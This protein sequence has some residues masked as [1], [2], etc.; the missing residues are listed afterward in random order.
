MRI[1]GV[2]LN[3]FPYYVHT[4]TFGTHVPIIHG[5]YVHLRTVNLNIQIKTN[6]IS[7]LIPQKHLTKSLVCISL[8]PSYQINIT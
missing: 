5:V 6:G 3:A 1:F 7:F 8:F 4:Y 2:Q